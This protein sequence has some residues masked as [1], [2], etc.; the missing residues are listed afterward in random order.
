[1]LERLRHDF[2]YRK[3]RSEADRNGGS[4]SAVMLENGSWSYFVV[5][6]EATDEEVRAL[7][8][9]I[10]HGRRMNQNERLLNEIAG[11]MTV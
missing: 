2:R 11:G 1:M 6:P 8:F 4:V 10:R 9:E 5:P 7:A 3:A